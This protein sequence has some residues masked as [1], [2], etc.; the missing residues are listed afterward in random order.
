MG[1]LLGKMGYLR[2]LYSVI[3]KQIDYGYTYVN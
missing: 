1:Y 3:K 2:Y